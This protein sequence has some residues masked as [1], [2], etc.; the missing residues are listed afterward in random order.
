MRRTQTLAWLYHN[1]PSSKLHSIHVQGL[2]FLLRPTKQSSKLVDSSFQDLY[3]AVPRAAMNQKWEYPLVKKLKEAKP[4]LETKAKSSQPII[5]SSTFVTAGNCSGKTRSNID[6]QQIVLKSSFSYETTRNTIITDT[7]SLCHWWDFYF[8]TPN[9]SSLCFT[10][11]LTQSFL[12]SQVLHAKEGE[13]EWFVLY[14]CVKKKRVDCVTKSYFPRSARQI[15]LYSLPSTF[16]K[17]NTQ[18]LK[19][20]GRRSTGKKGTLIFQFWIH[21]QYNQIGFFTLDLHAPDSDMHI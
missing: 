8:G 4:Y 10:E 12:R 13:K 15:N 11:M 16:S 5:S 21:R 18:I 3:R 7:P 17:F 2:H 19:L 6:T 14:F 1:L 9:K 20:V